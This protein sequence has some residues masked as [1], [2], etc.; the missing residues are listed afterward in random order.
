MKNQGLI[1][2]KLSNFLKDT[3][4]SLAMM[5]FDKKNCAIVENTIPHVIKI[6]ASLILRLNHEII[7]IMVNKAQIYVELGN[8]SLEVFKI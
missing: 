5:P 7:S 6:F 8:F 1:D 3:P 2:S 4:N